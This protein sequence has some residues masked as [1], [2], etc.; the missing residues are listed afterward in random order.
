LPCLVL[1]TREQAAVARRGRGHQADA[2][3]CGRPEVHVADGLLHAARF[4]EV[5]SIRELRA[6]EERA[7]A[8]SGGREEDDVADAG[9]L[10]RGE[11]RAVIL[12]PVDA[13]EEQE[14]HVGTVSAERLQGRDGDLGRRGADVTDEADA[15]LVGDDLQAAGERAEGTNR[16]GEGGVVDPRRRP[17]RTAGQIL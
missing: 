13:A 2:A 4:E 6:F 7:D 8:G 10:Q 15:V 5:E 14:V 1:G 11:E 9:A 16:G 12:L 3:R 17:M